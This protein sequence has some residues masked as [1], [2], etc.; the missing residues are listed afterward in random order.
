MPAKEYEESAV[1]VF[2]KRD[3]FPAKFFLIR[4]KKI[5]PGISGPR[6][7]LIQE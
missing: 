7:Y 2:F 5:T 1:I 3:S 6:E 4:L